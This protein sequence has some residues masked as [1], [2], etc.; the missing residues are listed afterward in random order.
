[1]TTEQRDQMI[2]DGMETS[3]ISLAGALSPDGNTVN[4]IHHSKH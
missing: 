2:R 1:M 4:T 3:E